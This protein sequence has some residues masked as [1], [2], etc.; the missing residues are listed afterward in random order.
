MFIHSPIDGVAFISISLA[1]CSLN[2]YIEATGSNRW[3]HPNL[4]PLSCIHSSFLLPYFTHP[5]VP[6]KFGPLSNLV[7]KLKQEA[8]S[9]A[10]RPSGFK[11][12]GLNGPILAEET[13]V[14]CLTS[15]RFHGV[16]K[17]V[18]NIGATLWGYCDDE[19][20]WYM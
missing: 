14:Y 16:Y 15:L 6:E 11:L 5:Q 20:C 17:I 2:A 8:L 7:E 3:S 18:M 4:S 10:V 9:C 19:R 13:Q 12:R 1:Y